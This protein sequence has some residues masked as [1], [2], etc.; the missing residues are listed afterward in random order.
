M[1]EIISSFDLPDGHMAAGS[2]LTTS[3]KAGPEL[4]VMPSHALSAKSQTL[5]N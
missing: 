2:L 3:Q 4:S 5:E 1:S